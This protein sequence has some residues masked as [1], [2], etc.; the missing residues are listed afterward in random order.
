MTEGSTA[1][2]SLALAQITFGRSAEKVRCRALTLMREP[3]QILP[4]SRADQWT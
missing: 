3:D 2:Q 4:T 1:T